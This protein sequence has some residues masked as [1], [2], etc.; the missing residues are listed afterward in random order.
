MERT[1]AA[2]FDMMGGIFMQPV[3]IPAVFAPEVQNRKGLRT[4]E[5]PRVRAAALRTD[6]TLGGRNLGSTG[7]LFGAPLRRNG[8]LAA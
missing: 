1:R 5:N 4:A 6:L 7:A 2:Q 8:L 3:T